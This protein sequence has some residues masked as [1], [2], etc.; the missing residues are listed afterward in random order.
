MSLLPTLP[1]PPLYDNLINEN[2]MIT[3]AWRN[4]F[5]LL[6]IGLQGSKFDSLS[7]SE[8]DTPQAPDAGIILYAKDDNNLYAKNQNGSEYKITP[9]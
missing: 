6:Q 9:F 1:P 5:S 8:V 3:D 2:G 7:L 4:W